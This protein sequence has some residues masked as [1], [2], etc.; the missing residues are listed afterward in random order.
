ME[1][2]DPSEARRLRLRYAGTCTVCETDLPARTAAIYDRRS[3][4][5]RC[6]DCG[7]AGHLADPVVFDVREGSPLRAT[8]GSESLTYRTALAATGLR[9]EAPAGGLT[10]PGPGSRPGSTWQ[11]QLSRCSISAGS[12]TMRRGAK[13]SSS[14]RNNSC[15]A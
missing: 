1:T 13:G 8:A 5:V 7:P 2:D 9:D 3:K 15:T 12:R 11:P 14:L 10:G 4:T 6:L